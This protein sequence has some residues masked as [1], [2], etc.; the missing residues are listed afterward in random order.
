MYLYLGNCRKAA[1]A[2]ATHAAACSLTAGTE[3]C[4]NDQLITLRSFMKISAKHSS[5]LLPPH[6]DIQSNTTE[7]KKDKLATKILYPLNDGGIKRTS[8]EA[9]GLSATMENVLNH[10]PQDIKKQEMTNA[11]LNGRKAKNSSLSYHSHKH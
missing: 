7:Q 10:P 2:A 3:Q 5:T 9:P 11:D 4:N 8:I 1:K 6:R